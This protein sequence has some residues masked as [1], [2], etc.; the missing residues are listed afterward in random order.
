MG[1]LHPPIIG[2][3]FDGVAAYGFYLKDDNANH[4]A[5]IALDDFVGHEHDD[6][7]YHYHYH[8]HYHAAS[9]DQTSKR[10]GS[11]CTLHELGPLGASA[12][13]INKV[14]EFQERIRRSIWLGN[15]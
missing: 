4:G 8:Y 11:A 6:Y 5:S 3:G 7:G 2:I 10:G 15:P 13:R 12:G 9:S 1:V 14:P